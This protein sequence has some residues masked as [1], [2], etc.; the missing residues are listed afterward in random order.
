MFL[1]EIGDW[2]SERQLK[3]VRNLQDSAIHVS[4]SRSLYVDSI[5]ERSAVSDVWPPRNLLKLILQIE[6]D[7]QLDVHCELEV[8]VVTC[9]MVVIVPLAQQEIHLIF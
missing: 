8:P 2:I 3:N 6:A 9:P 5:A 1:I 4:V 7:L